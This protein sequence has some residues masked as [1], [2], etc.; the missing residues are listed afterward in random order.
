MVMR[1]ELESHYLGSNLGRII[2]SGPWHLPSFLSLKFPHLYN[3]GFKKQTK[4]KTGPSEH[5]ERVVTNIFTKLDKG[6][7]Q[8]WT[9]GVKRLP[10]ARLFI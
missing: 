7:G 9:R 10:V 8:E 5:L 4:T 2:F 1:L 3:K 6:H